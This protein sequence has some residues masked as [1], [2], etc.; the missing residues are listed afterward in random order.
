M[1]LVRSEGGGSVKSFRGLVAVVVVGVVLG[2][3]SAA[4]AKPLTETQWKKKGNAICK[5]INK[6]L[7]SIGNEVFADLGP[8]EQPTDA[9][10]SDF[11]EQV[12][13]VV[14]DG[15]AAINKLDEPK[16]VK[17][18]LKKFNS[19]VGKLIVK[20]DTDPSVLLANEDP[21]KSVNKAAR[22]VGLT[23]CAN[24]QG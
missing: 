20:L 2:S 17:K 22:G 12:L 8:T 6:Q 4:F 24:S 14:E 10:L 11:V 5:D 15:I 3:A 9:Q 19:E 18:A 7:S 1:M 23:A 13:P 16:P 21:F